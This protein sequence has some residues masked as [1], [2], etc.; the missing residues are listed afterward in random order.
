V[1]LISFVNKKDGIFCLIEIFLELCRK[2][3]IN[4][5]NQTIMKKFYTNVLLVI[6]LIIASNSNATTKWID[7]TS[8]Y[9]KNPSFSNSSYSEWTVSGS[10]KSI[11][12]RVGCMEMWNGEFMMTK[13]IKL[14]LGHYRLSVNALYRVQDHETSYKLHKAGTEDIRG[15]LFVDNKTQKLASQYTFGFSSDP[16]ATCYNI[17]GLYYPNSMEAAELAFNQGE[18]LN[19]ME[20]D[21]T[22]DDSVAIGVY[23]DASVSDNW[24]V[25]DNFR[26][27]KYEDINEATK[28]SLYINELMP[29]NVDFKMS[30]AYNFDSWIELYNI[31]DKSI[32]LGGC[33]LSDDG[34]NLT[35]WRIPDAIGSVSSHGYKTLWLGSNEV[36]RNEP[37]FKLDCE[38]GT[39]Y[40]S[41]SSGAL[42]TS[43]TYPVGRGR[44]SY[45]RIT[46]GN[47]TW[48]WTAEPTPNASNRTSTFPAEQLAKP[49]VTPDGC[50]FNS[51]VNIN[52]TIPTGATLR[53]TDNGTTPTLT[54]GNTSTTGIFTTAENISYR[55]RLFQDGKL[56]SEVVTRT[57]IKRDHNYTLPI[58]SVSTNHAYLYSDSIGVY[59]KGTNGR[60]GNGQSTPANWNMDWDRPVN[61]QYIIPQTN[62][63]AVNQDVDFAISGGWTR[64]NDPKA[65][66]LKADRVYEGLNS[67]DYPFFSAKPY[68]KNKTVQMRAGGNDSWCR[69]K[70]AALQTIIQR[71]GQNL[72]L[73]SYQ[74]AVHF[75]N[76]VYKGLINVREPNNKDFAYANFGYSSDELDVYEQS[77]DSGA[78]MMVG[79]MAALNRLYEL[80]ANATEDASYE[81][82][83]SLLDIDEYINYMAAQLYLGS[84][85]WP[86]N[87][88]KAYRKTDGGKYRFVIFDLDAAFGT[89]DRTTDENGNPI[90]KNTFRWIDGMQWHW[91]DYIYDEGARRHGE[92][93]FC[94]FFLN[95][96]NNA[97]FRRRFIDAFCIMGGSVLTP[98]KAEPI[99]ADLG[100][101][102]RTTMSWEGAS[103]DGSLNEIRTKLNG[104]VADMT[105]DMI[106]YERLQLKNVSPHIAKLNSNNSHAQLLINDHVV[107]Y[108][109]FDGRLFA[110]IKFKAIAPSGYKFDGWKEFSTSTSKVFAK[111]STW[112]YYDQG[113]LDGKTWYTNYFNDASWTS[114][115]APLGYGKDLIKTTLS[116]GNNVSDKRPTYYFR[117]TVTLDELPN[118]D[119]TLNFTADDGFVI[120]V[121]GKEGGRYN[122]ASGT[123][124][125]STFAS[126]A[127]SNPDYGTMKLSASLFRAGQNVI[128]VEVHNNNATS[129]DIVWDGE[130]ILNNTTLNNNYYSTE[131]E[132]DMPTDSVFSL[133]ACFS[134]MTD[135]E[136]TAA[137][138]TPVV[139]NEVSCQNSI[140]V[141]DYFKRKDWVEL[142]NTTDNEIDA[143]GMYLSDK[144]DTP[145]KY[146]ISKAKGTASTI[147]PAHG[148]LIVW[149]DKD[150]TASQL[151]A[152]FK[153]DDG[154]GSIILTAKDKSWS[155]T[156]KYTAHNGD[157]TE[158]RY[159]DG[160]NNVYSMNI[161]TIAASNILTSYMQTIEQPVVNGIETVNSDSS[162]GLA[163]NYASGA[164]YIKNATAGQININVYSIAGQQILSGTVNAS[165]SG[166]CL[167]YMDKL[168]HG[169][170]VAHVRDSKGHTASCKFLK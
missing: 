109:T 133:E 87:N 48:A 81:E 99:L 162:D 36:T 135:E 113:S 90:Y 120:Y 71:A 141:N 11:T 66:K 96:L 110:P 83:K 77:P 69:I 3:F 128:A 14:P 158:G 165:A 130:I 37:P 119:L 20:F 107:P 138:M 54:N 108:N 105:Q 112:K 160:T 2:Y 19:Q 22:K 32:W 79:T 121:N 116:Y 56:P 145:F 134:E 42:L 155:N 76:G 44:L 103:P 6:F 5:R 18:F 127:N 52:V 136:K 49:I 24:L 100:N 152:S 89:D 28:G 41:D 170:Y 64:A 70:D 84:W 21:V 129:S 38:G 35:K 63:M 13:N 59:V 143:D 65:F 163:L 102:V 12:A 91:Y 10:A 95:M 88:V 157:A 115:N 17:D 27:E 94:T 132:I 33:Y 60:T 151:H 148:F 26:I 51:N 169:C 117:S 150:A 140:Y 43:M 167:V 149:C 101:A 154:G 168:Q 23:N 147:I 80:S 118:D 31:T 104:R 156:L 93:K 7:L 29:A 166:E 126:T 106:D 131:N 9:L 164:L 111:G 75:I 137:G 45:A 15:F 53:Y 78:Y 16:G 61:F 72:D 139:I 50:L 92:I 97:D 46:D 57:Y 125:Y 114:G 153:I 8:S 67:I 124:N 122:I 40:L 86:D 146:Q 142:Y 82:I 123:V 68:I 30:P 58:I 98:E 161:P 47:N 1:I 39:I 4:Y 25:C 62:T 73:C 34:T 85:D 55:F 144:A 159:P 74:P